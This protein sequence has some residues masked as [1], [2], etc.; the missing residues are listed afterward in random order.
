MKKSLIFSVA[1]LSYLMVGCSQKAPEVEP[2][3]IN[4]HTPVQQVQTRD[5]GVG[6]Q[7][8][9]AIPADAIDGGSIDGDINNMQSVGVQSD[10]MVI[11]DGIGGSGAGANGIQPV[12][13]A[14][15]KAVLS[16]RELDKAINNASVI[17]SKGASKVR[18]EGNCDEWGTDEYNYALGL[19]RA[20]AAKEALVANGVPRESVTTLSNG[21][22]NPVCHEH[23]DAC[24]Q[25][26]RRADFK[27]LR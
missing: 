9:N 15:D 25:R 27:L 6:Y 20:K 24:W 10:A 21:E 3:V 16:D 8:P 23:N 2:V 5:A 1:V 11:D 22:S 4:K 26:N 12:Y 17:K 19:K 13:F 14:F 7:D 18:V